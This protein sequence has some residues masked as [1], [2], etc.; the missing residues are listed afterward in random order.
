MHAR[1]PRH[2]GDPQAVDLRADPAPWWRAATAADRANPA[3]AHRS[4]APPPAHRRAAPDIPDRPG[5]SR[6]RARTSPRR[7]WAPS[8]R[9]T[10]SPKRSSS[11]T[12]SGSG[13]APSRATSRCATWIL[14]PISAPQ[15]TSAAELPATSAMPPIAAQRGAGRHDQQQRRGP[16]EG[17]PVRPPAPRAPDQH[18]DDRGGEGDRHSAA[19]APGR[20][21]TGLRAAEKRGGGDDQRRGRRPEWRAAR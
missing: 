10:C 15:V 13:S 18:P 4:S 16:Q 19:D 2:L 3:S 17:V 5:P 12:A 20:V 8:R 21:L 11:G 7:W 14:P 9:R 6:A 1:H